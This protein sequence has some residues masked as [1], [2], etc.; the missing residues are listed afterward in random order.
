MATTASG[1]KTLMIQSQYNPPVPTQ[2]FLSTHTSEFVLTGMLEAISALATEENRDVLKCHAL[3]TT[4]RKQYSPANSLLSWVSL[5]ILWHSIFIQLH[6]DFDTLEIALGRDG[7]EASCKALP[8]VQQWVVSLDARRCMLH[9]ILIQNL[10]GSLPV[11][12]ESAIY[13]PLC[14][15]HCGIIMACH[16]FFGD[17]N[18]VKVNIEEVDYLDFVEFQLGGGEDSLKRAS[19]ESKSLAINPVFRFAGLLYRIGHWRLAHSLAAS[20]LALVDC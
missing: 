19:S 14:L 11:G 7:Y 2:T 3:L 13:I 15:Y 5:L 10:F 6:V 16:W 12:G 1:W 4:W 18:K 17:R 9:T 20:L 8:H